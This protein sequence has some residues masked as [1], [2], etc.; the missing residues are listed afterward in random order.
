MPFL[1][2]YQVLLLSWSLAVAAVEQKGLP[3]FLKL[4]RQIK[5]ETM[6]W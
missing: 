4:W 6:L 3:H 1:P 5:K 2:L